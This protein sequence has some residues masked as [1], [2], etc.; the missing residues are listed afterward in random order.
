[1]HLKTGV[2]LKNIIVDNAFQDKRNKHKIR[3]F[4]AIHSFVTT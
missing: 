2:D 3:P 4:K 1:M